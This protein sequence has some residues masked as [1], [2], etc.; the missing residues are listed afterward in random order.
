MKTVL[1]DIAATSSSD[2][3]AQSKK[4]GYELPADGKG[5]RGTETGSSE[6]LLQYH[7]D[8][9]ELSEFGQVDAKVVDDPNMETVALEALRIRDDSQLNPW[10]FRMFFLGMFSVT[11]STMISS[12][13]FR[14]RAVCLWLR[15]SNDIPLQTPTRV[16]V[17]HILDGAQ[18]RCGIWDG[19]DHSK[20]RLHRSMVQPA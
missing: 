12:H 6:S 16:R 10:T 7:T 3:R 17:R 9:V 14:H 2:A 1:K 15:A 13:P 8:D 20:N 18:L 4:K 5:F 11:M 19:N